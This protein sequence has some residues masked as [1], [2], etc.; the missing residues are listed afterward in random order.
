MII[1][2]LMI[3][4]ASATVDDPGGGQP[5]AQG[6]GTAWYSPVV[7]AVPSVVPQTI[8]DTVTNACPMAS[9]R[10]LVTVDLTGPTSASDRQY[11]TPGK[12]LEYVVSVKNDGQAN[13]D[14]ELS[15]NPESCRPDWFSWSTT[16]LKVPA[17]VSRS[18][19]LVVHPD[20]DAG[21][22]SYGF[23]V[24]ASAKC[25]YPGKAPVT[26]QIQGLITPQRP[27]SAVPAS[28]RSTRTSGP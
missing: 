13:V 17:G 14:A 2:L 24:E 12:A 21:P 6:G 27:P 20:E 8:T 9:G 7:Q 15:I 28:S 5:S 19:A 11:T 1:L 23:E 10:L 25:S 16:C 4:Q 22:G 26:F 3:C 18:E